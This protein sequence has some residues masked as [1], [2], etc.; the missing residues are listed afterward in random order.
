MLLIITDSAKG[1][2]N[3]KRELESLQMV[4]EFLNY[5]YEDKDYFIQKKFTTKL[6]NQ[7]EVIISVREKNNQNN[8]KVDY[9]RQ[10]I[11]LIK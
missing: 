9:C 7:C 10:N 1:Y 6:I 2:E 11:K 5:S 3:Y 4:M 8:F